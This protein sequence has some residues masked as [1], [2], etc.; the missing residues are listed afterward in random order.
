[1]FPRRRPPV[2]QPHPFSLQPM[3][4]RPIYQQP[5]EQ[6]TTD[7][8]KMLIQDNDGNFDLEKI[9]TTVQQVNQIYGHISPMISRFIK[10]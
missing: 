4:R 6:K 9:T 3:R 10:K 2:N 1:M 8:L 7:K 5:Q